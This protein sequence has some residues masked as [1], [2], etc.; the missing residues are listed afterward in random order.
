MPSPF[1]GMDP[2]LEARWRDVHTRLIIYVTDALQE[3]LPPELRARVEERIVLETEEGLSRGLYPDV[4][5]VEHPPRS[6][7]APQQ[8]NGVAVIQPETYAVA[9]EPLT[10]GFIQI[11][12]ANTGNRVVTL[13]EI[14]SPS[15]KTSGADREAYR[16]K[17][18]QTCSS[19]TNLVE[20]DL[21]RTGLHT[22]AFPLDCIPE[23][24]RTPYYV[25]VRRATKPGLADVYRI[26][27]LAK[28]PVVA[29]PLRPTDSDVTLDLQAL[30]DQVYR[31][32]RYE[33]DLDYNKDPEPPFQDP[34]A[35]DLD[36]FLRDKGVR[37]RTPPLPRRR[38]RKS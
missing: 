28:L 32:G 13:I 12:D 5:V 25:C 34:D 36:H 9:S 23:N 30:I 15:N 6:A 20:I 14:L 1:P 35:K 38:K 21:L 24:K 11:I 3:Q 18:R 26:P 19:D 37:D 22:V 31:R 33:G 27:L 8:G 2:Y 4:R 10:E 7:F 17:Q 29:V 16:A